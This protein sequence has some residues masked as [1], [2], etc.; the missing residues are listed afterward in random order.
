MFGDRVVFSLIKPR[1]FRAMALLMSFLQLTSSCLDTP[2]AFTVSGAPLYR[3]EHFILLY[4]ST[5]SMRSSNFS[6]V[7]VFGSRIVHLASRLSTLMLQDD[8]HDN[9]AAGPMYDLYLQ[10]STKVGHM[11]LESGSG[12]AWSVLIVRAVQCL[13]RRPVI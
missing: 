3:N 1:A 6:I 12:C 13:L 2:S 4:L 11:F 5:L 7:G 8:A 10:H 9:V